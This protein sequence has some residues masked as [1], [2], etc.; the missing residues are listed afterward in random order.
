MNFHQVQS[1]NGS[2]GEATMW[3]CPPKANPHMR[4]NNLNNK[5]ANRRGPNQF[6]PPLNQP[7]PV[8]PDNRQN[9]QGAPN[10][11][12]KKSDHR[13]HPDGYTAGVSENLR[14]RVEDEKDIPL[15]DAVSAGM[16]AGL[17]TA[18]VAIG[19]NV[20]LADGA[21]TAR[22]INSATDKVAADRITFQNDRV[23]RRQK[24]LDDHQHT[25][26]DTRE[27]LRLLPLKDA[28]ADRREARALARDQPRQHSLMTR[29]INEKAAMAEVDRLAAENKLISEGTL[30]HSNILLNKLLASSY[31]ELELALDPRL[32]E[33]KDLQ[34]A[35]EEAD[36]KRN[37]PK[38][39]KIEEAKYKLNAALEG[40]K[41]KD[42]SRL[43]KAIEFVMSPTEHR[44]RFILKT[45]SP[46]TIFP[47]LNKELL[48]DRR[49]MDVVDT[50]LIPGILFVVQGKQTWKQYLGG[51][52]LTHWKRTVK[53]F[54]ISDDCAEGSE[55]WVSPTYATNT[56]PDWQNFHGR[57]SVTT[58][59]D[60]RMHRSILQDYKFL[61]MEVQS[62]FNILN[63]TK[64]WITKGGYTHTRCTH[65]HPALYQQ[66]MLAATGNRITGNYV[67]AL[68]RDFKSEWLR[69]IDVT[70]FEDTIL[71]AA[72]NVAILN[73][74]AESTIMASQGAIPS[75]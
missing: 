44:N 51:G 33:L 10:A 68:K 70:L 41:A 61:G 52:L 45:H 48:D 71:L 46:G 36:Y 65:V 59:A 30:E 26:N 11:P 34:I 54:A 13:F 74:Y 6:G 49:Y 32:Q 35:K 58:R 60:R 4:R 27:E 3:N 67:N 16:R 21:R 66:C 28:I 62:F 56:Y 63:G 17:Y 18:G 19:E 43:T 72:Q 15:P 12:E 25:L 37:L 7:P 1:L 23:K 69:Y 20:P 40:G 64:N 47:R 38:L 14:Y 5:G 2:H 39:L 50:R 53:G 75:T 42:T 24:Q 57:T 8:H 9:Q 55:R 31:A 29:R 22:S 73:D